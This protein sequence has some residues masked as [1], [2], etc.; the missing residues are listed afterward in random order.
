MNPS[1]T[2]QDL[3]KEFPR[4]PIKTNEILAPYT[5]F[6]IG[7]PAEIFATTE[8]SD[9]LKNLLIFIKTN[10]P[11]LPITILGNAS[12]VLVADSGLKGLVIKNNSQNIKILPPDLNLNQLSTKKTIPNHRTELD[13]EKYLDFSSLDYDESDKPQISVEIESGVPLPYALAYLFKKKITG[14]QW[15]AGIPGTLGGATWYNIHGGKYHF[16]NFIK[17]VSVLNFKTGKEEL[18]PAKDLAFS[19]DYSIFQKKPHLII[20]STTLNLYRGDIK[21]ARTTAQK[22]IGQ[23]ANCQPLPSAGSVFQNLDPTLAKKHGFKSPSIGWIID[24][25]LNLKGKT[26]GGAQISPFHANFIVNQKKA[27]AKDVLSLIGLIKKEFKKR[28]NIDLKLEIKLL[29]KI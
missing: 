5:T 25:L 8:S 26:I 21:K 9:Q 27:T 10:Y 13:P 18:L 17:E 1:K 22:W 24:Q 20:L 29:G 3:Q 4:L 19:Y 6:K 12:N 14:L 23:K 11:R 7:G 15:F 16:S 2:A 28:W